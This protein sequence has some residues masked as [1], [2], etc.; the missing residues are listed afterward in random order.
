MAEKLINLDNLNTFKLNLVESTDGSINVKNENESK[1]D[2]SIKISEET[3]NALEVKD[4]GIYSG[5]ADGLVEVDVVPYPYKR[6]KK[7]YK[8]PY[9]EYKLYT[10]KGETYYESWELGEARYTSGTMFPNTTLAEEIARWRSEVVGSYINAVSGGDD[11]VL[12]KIESVA[13][14]GQLYYGTTNIGVLLQGGP[15]V[16]YNGAGTI[17]SNVVFGPLK[18]AEV[19]AKEVQLATKDDL[20]N[21]DIDTTDFVKKENL[22]DKSITSLKVKLADGDVTI[23][24]NS[25]TT[26]TSSDFNVGGQ[27]TDIY[28]KGNTINL[29][30]ISELDITAGD[31]L[32]INTTGS[33][34][35]IGSGTEPLYLNG[36]GAT[37]DVDG[38]INITPK[39]DSKLK[40]VSDQIEIKSR[41]P[42]GDN[43][44]KLYPYNREGESS[45]LIVS[46]DDIEV[47]VL[48]TTFRLEDNY[49][50]IT[51]GNGETE[52]GDIWIDSD[53]WVCMRAN[54]QYRVDLIQDDNSVYQSGKTKNVIF[55]NWDSD[56]EGDPY[57]KLNTTISGDILTL[58]APIIN[59]NGV[60]KKPW[61]LVHEQH[62]LYSGEGKRYVFDL[63]SVINK[64]SEMALYLTDDYEN[65]PYM[66]IYKVFDLELIKNY[67]WFVS[68]DNQGWFNLDRLYRWDSEKGTLKRQNINLR[69]RLDEVYGKFALECEET[70]F[71]NDGQIFRVFMR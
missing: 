36:T 69:F 3:G 61:T 6:E 2:L 38:D 26:N 57:N 10:G 29:N 30:T 15:N 47:N 20:K 44:L 8:T 42:S 21:I 60:V 19:Y 52:Q 70:T 31:E 39:S 27:N 65:N 32:L 71:N 13:D 34:I 25:I 46:K 23:G 48:S 63:S 17:Y 66:T 24:D 11:K 37:L 54:Q 35:T 1:I 7:I 56:D 5:S 67:M 16:I 68:S 33:P 49:L 14:N 43:S 4:D 50:G 51:S 62:Y 41:K 18:M 53:G 28:V 64:Y 59:I 22:T 12:L 45:N 40:I 58:K 55:A 9:G